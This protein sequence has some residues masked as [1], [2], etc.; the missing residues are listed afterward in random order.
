MR[1]I[2]QDLKNQNIKTLF[3][4]VFLINYNQANYFYKAVQPKT[5][6]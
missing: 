6:S 5:V 2:Y 1:H 3:G 4:V